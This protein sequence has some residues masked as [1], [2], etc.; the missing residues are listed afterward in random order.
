MTKPSDEIRE[1][2]AAARA[3]ARYT[4]RHLA[5]GSFCESGPEEQRLLDA[6]ERV[7]G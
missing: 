4:K 5:D 1:L 2:I 7:K 3:W 6:I